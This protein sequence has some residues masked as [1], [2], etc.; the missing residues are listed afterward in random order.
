MQ[1]KCKKVKKYQILKKTERQGESVKKRQLDRKRQQ[2][3][4]VR[5][6]KRKSDKVISR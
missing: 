6:R 5:E 2:N 4:R 1:I 3:E